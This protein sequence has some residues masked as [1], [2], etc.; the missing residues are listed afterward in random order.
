M[1]VNF[2]IMRRNC[3][4]CLF[5]VH[6]DFLRLP[7]FFFIY[8]LHSDSVETDDEGRLYCEC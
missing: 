6:L 5:S 2:H 8:T 3:I 1:D 4:G 7:L